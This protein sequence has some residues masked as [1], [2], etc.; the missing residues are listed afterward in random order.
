VVV[1]AAGDTGFEQIEVHFKWAE[2]AVFGG[3]RPGE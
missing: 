1:S 3:T 2:A